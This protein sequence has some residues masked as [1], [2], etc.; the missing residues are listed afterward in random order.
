[1]KSIILFF[2][3]LS[4]LI[5]SCSTD[6]SSLDGDG[7]GPI[8]EDQID[9]DSKRGIILQ[10]QEEYPELELDDVCID[11]CYR[12]KNLYI[13]GFFAHD[14]G[15][16]GARYFFKG[17]EVTFDDK[18]VKEVLAHNGF[19]SNRLEVVEAYHAEVINHYEHDLSSE[20]ERFA[21][22]GET[23]F[24]PKVY[25]EGNRIISTMWIQERG[26][27]LPEVGYH[28]STLTM[29]LNG[30]PV[31]YSTSNSFIVEY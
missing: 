4:V 18:T 15:C 1:M 16:G 14:R 21:E 30:V 24:A 23:F 13:V 8:T 11:S 22:G 17:K 2:S 31:D 9:P 27:M 5:F 28:I 20:P 6:S 26:G 10:L 19:K 7:D 25:K 29:D 3:F 12:L